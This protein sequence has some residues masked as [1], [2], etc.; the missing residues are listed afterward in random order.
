MSCPLSPFIDCLRVKINPP[1]FECQPARCVT[2]SIDCYG[3]YGEFSWLLK[4]IKRTSGPTGLGDIKPLGIRIWNELLKR[5]VFVQVPSRYKL[6]VFLSTRIVS[7]IDNSAI[8]PVA[9][10]QN[11][12]RV[13]GVLKT[14]VAGFRRLSGSYD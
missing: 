9:R 7:Y 5:L 12:W 3:A 1:L 6:P 14:P 13:Y 8:D 11:N 4:P 10:G 2:F